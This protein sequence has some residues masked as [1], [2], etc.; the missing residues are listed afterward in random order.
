[1]SAVENIRPP[2]LNPN[3]SY[4]LLYP[5]VWQEGEEKKMLERVQL[6]RMTAAE[7]IISEGP[8][9]RTERLVKILASV[10]SEMEVVLRKIDW[11]DCDR[12]DECLGFFTEHG[13]AT[14]VIS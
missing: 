2:F 4:D 8:E 5:V 10:T 3:N 6:R 12:L 7:K 13:P 11:V 14:G 1:M 9:T